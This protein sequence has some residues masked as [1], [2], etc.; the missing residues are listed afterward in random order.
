[1]DAETPLMESPPSFTLQMLQDAVLG[2]T[3][4]L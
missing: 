3:N 2:L 4:H 1:M